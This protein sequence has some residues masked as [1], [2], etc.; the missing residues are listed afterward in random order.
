[1]LPLLTSQSAA[2]VD[3]RSQSEFGL[4]AEGLMEIAGAL[5]AREIEAQYFHELRRG[6]VVVV[7]GPGHNGGDGLVI[8]R[9]LK[10]QGRDVRVALPGAAEKP[11][12]LFQM[13]RDRLKKY[14]LPDLHDPSQLNSATLIIDCLFGTGLNKPIA[15]PYLRWVKAMVQTGVPIVSVDCPS[16]LNVSTGVPM[17]QVVAASTTLTL[18]AAKAGFYLNDGPRLCGR[19]RI[20]N[21]GFP[22]SL[23]HQESNRLSLFEREDAQA[24]LPNRTEHSHKSSHGHVMVLA[25][26]PGMW[27]AGVLASHSAYRVGAG[28]VTWASFEN[29]PILESPECLVRVITPEIFKLPHIRAW[30]VGPGLPSTSHTANLLFELKQIKATNVVVD[31]GALIAAKAEGAFPFPPSWILTPHAGELERLLGVPATQLDSDRVHSTQLAQ[32]TLGGTVLFKGFHTVIADHQETRIISTGNPAL[33]K[34]GTGDVLAGFI[35]GLMA[36]GLRGIEAA[37]VGSLIH[38][39]LADD[40]VA[41]GG[42]PSS[43]MA[44]DLYK[45]VPRLLNQLR[46]NI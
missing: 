5:C 17:G 36:Q 43:L 7:C 23:V 24:L 4:S 2:R 37:S 9:L 3:Q 28:Y 45:L 11:S 12:Q 22:P 21:I 39:Q 26:Q 32:K 34:A 44:S 33:A 25:G 16:G 8:A 18:G 35:A 6:P 42:D 46:Q 10:S 19:L 27:G 15:E 38:G 1:M 31:A 41:A 40:F 20:L 29:P 30:V 13:Q 14:I